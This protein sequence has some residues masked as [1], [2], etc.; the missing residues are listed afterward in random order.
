MSI[1][2]TNQQRVFIESQ[3]SISPKLGDDYC[4]LSFDWWKKLNSKFQNDSIELDPIDN[5]TLL[6]ETT[7]VT[8]FAILKQSLVEGIDYVLVNEATWKSLVHWYILYFLVI[9]K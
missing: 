6:S 4:L 9:S 7:I 2:S 3:I 1:P 8:E 5:S